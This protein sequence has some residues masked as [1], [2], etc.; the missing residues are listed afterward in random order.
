MEGQLHD[1]RTAR[2]WSVTIQVENGRVVAR[3]VEDP[4][5]G[6][7]WPLGEVRE[8]LR[9][10]GRYSLSR[11]DE[12]AR[13]IVETEGW[14]ALAG[15]SHGEI[16]RRGRGREWA[17][18]GGLVGAG[19]AV[20][21]VVFIGVPMAA[22][23]LARHT[24]PELEARF[25]VSMEKQLTVP[26]RPC[27]AD[28][29]AATLLSDL[30]ERLGK[31]ADAPFPIRVRAIRAPFVNAFALPGGT[32]LVTGRLIEEARGPD[33]L[34][35]VLAHEIAH[36]ERRHVMQAAW[37]AM[38]A[39]LLLDAVV[40]GGSGAGQQ[41]VVLAGGFADHR[42]S[43]TLEAEADD[44]AIQILHAQNIST[45]GMADFFDRLANR[46]DDP[47]LRQA[48]EWF[49]THPDTAGRADKAKRAIRPGQPALSDRDWAILD[50]VCRVVDAPKPKSRNA[51]R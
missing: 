50:R 24:P 35:A 10:D 1:G 27:K 17:L 19:L 38:G 16:K 44:R 23:P 6:L 20:A 43:R 9:S 47:R 18:V 28:T 46:G 25:G 26:F 5:V 34:A 11:G 21:A 12:D 49:Q 7:D 15:R 30:G 40:G 45:Q 32:I 42:F 13:L 31:A 41:L 33:E 51:V 39:G 3:A 48:A 8:T 36:V 29:E 4:S 14:R 22:G 37:R 2:P